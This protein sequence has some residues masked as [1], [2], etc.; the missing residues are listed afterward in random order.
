MP[1]WVFGPLRTPRSSKIYNKKINQFMME[2]YKSKERKPDFAPKGAS[3]VC[4]RERE[5]KENVMHLVT[6]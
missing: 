6:W 4:P 3:V 2:L 1:S 5:C